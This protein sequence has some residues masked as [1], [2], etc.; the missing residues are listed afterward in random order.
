MSADYRIT[1]HFESR[2]A[3]TLVYNEMLEGRRDT[4]I[5]LACRRDSRLNKFRQIFV[6]ISKVSP[7]IREKSCQKFVTISV[8]P[9]STLLSYCQ[10]VVTIT[11]VLVGFHK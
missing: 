5:V 3:C 8:P 10:I 1:G 4:L 7:N 6:T 9:R 2:F 11:K